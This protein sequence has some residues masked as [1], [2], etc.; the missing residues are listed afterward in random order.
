MKGRGAETLPACFATFRG[1][2]GQLFIASDARVLGNTR[3]ELLAVMHGMEEADIRITD[4]SHEEDNTHTKVLERGLCSI[5]H[6]RFLGN[7][8]AARKAGR[9]GGIGKGIAAQA[10][11]D[12]NVPKWLVRNIVNDRDIPWD[13][14]MRVL[15]NKFS[16]STLR[17]RYAEKT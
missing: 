2:P 11:R 1:L 8:R 7:S 6:A 16:Q 3:R 10:A 13:V 5:A 14:K 9:S 12:K 4:I 15:D 17:R